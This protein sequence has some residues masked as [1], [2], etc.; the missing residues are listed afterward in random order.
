MEHSPRSSHAAF[1]RLARLGARAVGARIGAVTL[2][3]G[4]A[5]AIAGAHAVP[6]GRTPSEHCRR[7]VAEGD[8][9]AA[10]AYLGV[11]V[12]DPDGTTV[13][14]VCV[15][16]PDRVWDAGD[17]A[18]LEDVAALVLAEIELRR[19][20]DAAR[21]EREVVSAVLDAATDCLVRLDAE[22]RILAWGAGA[23]RTFGFTGTDALGHLLPRLLSP[24]RKLEAYLEGLAGIMRGEGAGGRIEVV[25]QHR[26]G[27]EMPVE[28]TLVPA[29][30]GDTSP[31]T[32]PQRAARRGGAGRV[33]AAPV[34]RARRER[35]RRHLQLRLR[36]R[37]PRPLREPEIEE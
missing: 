26:D 34:P 1:D 16:D 29:G 12:R 22:G 6:A 4:D 17:R 35:P 25:A 3:E 21:Q 18:L 5:H 23:E 14:T 19:S 32:R 7:I 9:I 28:L 33:G 31:A 36:R 2:L 24:A 8:G 27:R 20:A 13:G 15:H 37:G 10:G 11:P 30:H